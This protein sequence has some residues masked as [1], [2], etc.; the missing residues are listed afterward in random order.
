MAI[1]PPSV[2]PAAV[3]PT[4]VLPT[5][6]LA[7]VAPA[8]WPQAVLPPQ[9]LSANRFDNLLAISAAIGGWSM[10]CGGLQAAAATA[11]PQG[12]GLLAQVSGPA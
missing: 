5:S 7:P 8:G 4:A 9:M 3:L 10:L 2:L 6:L 1:L 12:A 11:G